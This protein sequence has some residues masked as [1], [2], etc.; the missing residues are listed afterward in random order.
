MRFRNHR[1][2]LNTG[3]YG[4]RGLWCGPRD[5]TR[6]WFEGGNE[7]QSWED[8]SLDSAIYGGSAAVPSQ[9]RAINL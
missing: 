4:G 5:A 8:M 3:V 9:V 7:A 1:T 6:G 2:S